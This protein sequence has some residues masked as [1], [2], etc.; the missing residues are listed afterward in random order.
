MSSKITMAESSPRKS[1]WLNCNLLYDRKGSFTRLF[2]FNL[3]Y[4]IATCFKYAALD[5]S[6]C[7]I[8]L[9]LWSVELDSFFVEAPVSEKINL[10]SPLCGLTKCTLQF[11]G[12]QF[13]TKLQ[14]ILPVISLLSTWKCRVKCVLLRTMNTALFFCYTYCIFYSTLWVKL[15]DNLPKELHCRINCLMNFA[16]APTTSW[17]C[18]CTIY[19]SC[20]GFPACCWWTVLADCLPLMNSAAGSRAGYTVQWDL[21]PEVPRWNHHIA[22]WCGNIRFCCSFFILKNQTVAWVIG[23]CEPVNM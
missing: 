8:H 4:N 20:T 6:C 2:P 17:A 18:R 3:S 10:K 21:S 9:F 11:I 23:P 19:W 15:Q 16:A 14:V 1:Q 13:R 5:I 22:P 7:N 12:T